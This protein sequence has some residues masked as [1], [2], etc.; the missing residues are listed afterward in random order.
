MES[1]IH[2]FCSL[3]P[4]QLPMFTC[5]ALNPADAHCEG[6]SWVLQDGKFTLSV[7]ISMVGIYNHVRYRS[8]TPGKVMVMHARE[9][10]STLWGCLHCL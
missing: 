9:A 1:G 3:S 2:F 7:Q 10:F 4:C 6:F 5:K 8:L